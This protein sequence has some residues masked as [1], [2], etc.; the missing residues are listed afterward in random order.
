MITTFFPFWFL[1]LASVAA[2]IGLVSLV[3]QDANDDAGALFIVALLIIG[4][5][6][7]GILGNLYPVKQ[8]N[9]TVQ[10]QVM[11]NDTV[12]VCT[13]DGKVIYQSD[14]A[15]DVEYSKSH[16]II[17]FRAQRD[18]NMYGST[19]DPVTYTMIK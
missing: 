3:C 6:G 9:S 12:M 5:V 15:V 16:E 7:W 14:K 13:Y 10:S 2:L 11:V 1:V 17:E 18:I 4:L 8:S 19:N